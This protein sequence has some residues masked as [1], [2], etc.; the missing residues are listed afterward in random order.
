MGVDYQLIVWSQGSDPDQEKLRELF[1][2]LLPSPEDIAEV[3][4]S[5]SVVPLVQGSASFALKRDEPRLRQFRAVEEMLESPEILS[6]QF[7][8][9][10]SLGPGSQYFLKLF[11]QEDWSFPLE[12]RDEGLACELR[13]MVSQDSLL[14]DDC[15]CDTLDRIE[16][17]NGEP[18]DY[19]SDDLPY[20]E[21]TTLGPPAPYTIFYRN[22]YTGEEESLGV[23]S[24][25]VR[26]V[27]DFQGASPT[28]CDVPHLTQNH[29]LILEH[30]LGKVAMFGGWST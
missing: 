17:E 30:C 4:M 10:M 27:W 22:G 23:R 7:L 5:L 13:V 24:S 1:R 9:S 19:G 14:L 28:R 18:F 12:D 6:G 25:H 20:G 2:G 21:F 29:L 11:E 16:D 8:L 15:Y 26:L 3:S